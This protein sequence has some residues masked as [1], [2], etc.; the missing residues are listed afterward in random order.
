M[1]STILTRL[2]AGL[3]GSL[4]GLAILPM[5]TAFGTELDEELLKQLRRGHHVLLIR[6]ALAPG[7]GDPANFDVNDCGTQRN[8]NGRGRAQAVAIGERLR[9]L[10]IR[11]ERVASSEWCR[12][13]ETAALAFPNHSVER[14]PA[15]NS[16]FE[17]DQRHRGPQ[18]TADAM[19]RIGGWTRSKPSMA[20]NLVLVTH[21]VNI[22]A[23]TGVFPASGEAIVAQWDDDRFIVKGRLLVDAP[24]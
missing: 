22:T 14:L 1:Q 18:Q 23:L 7:T 17:D 5:P 8:L 16:F 12:C 13:L 2:M 6:H 15:L 21:Q 10:G 11:V 19:A 3:F 24:R 9:E 4:L 20:G